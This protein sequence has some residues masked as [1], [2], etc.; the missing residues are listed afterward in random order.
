MLFHFE[1]NLEQS[2]A[3]VSSA[4]FPDHHRYTD[5]DLSRLAEKAKSRE[6]VIVTT[7]KDWAKLT[8]TRWG[9]NGDGLSIYLCRMRFSFFK[10][11]QEQW[12]Q[13][14][15]RFIEKAAYVG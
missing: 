2:G 10:K 13:Y 1:K 7:E 12:D 5:K 15:D 14:L 4:R 3:Q 11:D 8:Q 9:R 6:S